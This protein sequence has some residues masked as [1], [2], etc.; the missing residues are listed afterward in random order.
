[1]SENFLNLARD[2]DVLEPK[3]PSDVFKT[4]ADAARGTAGQVDSARMNLAST[5][6]NAFVNAGFCNDKL[7]N[8][9]TSQVCT[10]SSHAIF[11]HT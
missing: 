1:L 10:L 9:S 5:I 2:L 11:L 3:L 6:V 4:S 7:L 8:V